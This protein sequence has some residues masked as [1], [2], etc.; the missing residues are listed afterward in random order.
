MKVEHHW[1]KAA[2]LQSRLEKSIH[3]AVTVERRRLAASFSCL[4]HLSL[5]SLLAIGVGVSLICPGDRFI[6]SLIPSSYLLLVKRRQD[7]SIEDNEV[8]VDVMPSVEG[9]ARIR[10]EMYMCAGTARHSL[11]NTMV[12]KEERSSE[13]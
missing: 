4:P 9:M 5:P 13:S 7:S 2:E 6:D 12:P 3:I 11:Y 10:L 1:Y 8:A